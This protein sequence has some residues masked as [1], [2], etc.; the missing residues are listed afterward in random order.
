MLAGCVNFS[1][2]DNL[3]QR[4]LSGT[5]G[6]ELTAVEWFYSLLTLLLTSI[7]LL[8]LILIISKQKTKT[9]KKKNLQGFALTLLKQFEQLKCWPILKLPV[10]DVLRYLWIFH[11]SG[12]WV[13]VGVLLM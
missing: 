12:S 5:D 2:S 8:K 6:P 10:Y 9:K 4:Y 7:Q 13:Y 1:F 11:V 3:S